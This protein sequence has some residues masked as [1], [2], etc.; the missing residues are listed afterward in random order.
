M[1]IQPNDLTLADLEG[2]KPD[3]GPNRSIRLAANVPNSITE[4]TFQSQW[5]P[6]CPF[7]FLLSELVTVNQTKLSR[8]GRVS[9]K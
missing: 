8:K 1:Q 5:G 6:I 9:I 4:E 7:S 3:Q 2:P